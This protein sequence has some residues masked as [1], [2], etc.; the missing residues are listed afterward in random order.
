MY[1][2]QVENV[3]VASKQSRVQSMFT[4]SS[5]GFYRYPPD[6]QHIGG[7]AMA[8]GE[9]AWSSFSAPWIWTIGSAECGDSIGQRQ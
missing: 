9:N 7:V 2:P 5:S 8:G 6:V 4:A 3:R 1:V